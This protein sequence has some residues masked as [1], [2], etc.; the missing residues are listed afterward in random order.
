MG[1]L[2]RGH[3]S[4]LVY[5]DCDGNEEVINGWG[6]EGEIV[7]EAGVPMG[8]SK[9]YRDPDT[10]KEERGAKQLDI[11]LAEGQTMADVWE[12]MKQAAQQIHDCGVR[13]RLFGTNTN[14][15]LYTILKRC[16]IVPCQ[17]DHVGKIDFYPGWG[18]EISKPCPVDEPSEGRGRRKS[19]PGPRWSMNPFPRDNPDSPLALDL[20]GDGIETV[21]LSAN[22]HFD[23]DGDSFKELTGAIAADD[24]LLVLDINGDGQINS[25][26]EL[27]GN[28]TLL[29]DG[30]LADNGFLALAEL[31]SNDDAIIDAEDARYAELRIWRDLNQDGVTDEGELFTLEDAGVQSLN[32]IYSEQRYTDRSG[33][34]HRQVGSYTTT[35]GEVRTMTDVWFTNNPTLTQET[36]I[37]V[38]SE[39]GDLPDINGNGRSHSLHQ[40]MARDESGKLQSL[41]EGFAVASTRAQ[42]LALT[43][44]IIFAWTGQEGEYRK[45]FNASIDARRMG[46]LEVFYGHEIYR[47]GHNGVNYSRVF[48]AIFDDVADAIFSRLSA[49]THLAV[50]F[51]EISW[52]ENAETGVWEADFSNVVDDLFDYAKDNPRQV[53]AIMQDFAQAIRGINSQN[54]V[55]VDLLGNAVG[56]F[57]VTADLSGYTGE[58]VGIIS[59]ALL[60]GAGGAERIIGDS[61][62][63]FLFGFGGNDQ[64]SGM[65][66]DDILDGGEGDDVLVGGAGDDE[67]RFGRVYGR[68]RIRNT[69]IGAGRND[70]VRLIGLT[71]EDVTVSRQGNDLVIAIND[72]EDVLRVESHFDG[73]GAAK[74]YINAIVFDDENK[75]VVGPSEFDAINVQSQSITEENDNVHGSSAVDTLDGLAGND[76][77][78]GKDGDDKLT[79]SGGDDRLYGDAGADTL[80]GDAGDDVLYGGKGADTLTGG[81]D[82]DTLYGGDGD[83]TLEGGIGEDHLVGGAGNDSYRFN[84]GDGLDV[85]DNQGVTGDTDKIVLG[86]GIV[87]QGLIIRRVDND[88]N[89]TIRARTDAILIKNYYVNASS[90]ID[91]LVFEDETSADASWDRAKLESVADTATSQ[92]DELHGDDTANSIDGLAGDDLLI[93][94]GGDDQLTGGAG[95]DLLRGGGGSDSYTVAADGSHD[96]IQENNNPADSNKI[97]F[98]EGITQADISYSR[99]ATDLIITIS[100][101][102]ILSTVTIQDSFRYR[103]NQIEQLVFADN[104]TVS[105]ATVLAAVSTWTGTDEGELIYGDVADDRLDGGAGND[106]LFGYGNDDNLSGEKGDDWLYGGGSN[107]VLDGGEG[108]DRLYG[109]ADHDHLYG[110]GGH[111]HLYGEAGNDRLYGDAGNDGLHGGIGSDSLFGGD[112]DDELHGGIG[113]DR[114]EGGAG[115]DTYLFGRG[116]CLQS[117]NILQHCPPLSIA[118]H[119]R[120]CPILTLTPP[121]VQVGTSP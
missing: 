2:F 21:G 29:A 48:N 96:I 22:I 111:D 119:W 46:A 51:R 28:N 118:A 35:S 98:A 90:R 44:Q 64:I 30:E 32:T 12:K 54:A 38:S 31:D 4:Y 43:E 20:D 117:L 25:G 115:N 58:T 24:G 49:Q 70:I 73:E 62:K 106:R 86:E 116:D 8:Q 1:G 53:Q 55:N 81:I 17:P 88:L 93:G 83:D 94:Y 59:S 76:K 40:A 77:I 7:T 95:D 9:D 112:G 6:I 27:F 26:A 14:S 91:S 16:G 114:L 60:K 3:H 15:V 19:G 82:H 99:T 79:G 68:D 105:I 100:K 72:S 84:F 18:I 61:G 107:D 110:N 5:K 121:P 92:D 52:S 57:I 37:E 108:N 75:L 120:L 39:I 78:Y 65:A 85:I 101:D 36:I 80:A 41:V 10:A 97:I 113:S 50:F 89:I 66:G 67:Y 63:D 47:P 109:G 71:N 42:R 56:K 23:H 33:N 69:D 74:R 11:P 34:Q 102:D 13:Y 104:T 87:S 103:R 45:H